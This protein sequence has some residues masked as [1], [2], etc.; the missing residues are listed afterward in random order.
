MASAEWTI[1]DTAPATFRDNTVNCCLAST[2]GFCRT[3]L[4]KYIKFYACFLSTKLTFDKHGSKFN[5]II[6]FIASNLHNSTICLLIKTDK[7]FLR[8]SNFITVMWK[9]MNSDF[10][11]LLTCVT[12]TQYTI[13]N[14]FYFMA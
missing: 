14:L 5:I 11:Q 9:N 8:S 13:T 3:C 6:G 4:T 12:N 10:C 2:E 1:S 7:L